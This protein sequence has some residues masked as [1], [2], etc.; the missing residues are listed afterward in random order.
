MTEEK[1]CSFMGLAVKARQAVSGSF[2]SDKAI[3]MGTA[4]LVLVA[5][6]ASEN[7]K[8]GFRDAGK[9]YNAT[10][11]ELGS[12][13]LLGKYSGK[14]SR[15]AIAITSESFA[16]KLLSMIDELEQNHG[17]AGIE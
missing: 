1:I 11:R 9:F 3:K 6:D 5:K 4:K 8:K 12:K 10:I 2:M 16:N 17:G 13:E 7:T 15:T 14:D